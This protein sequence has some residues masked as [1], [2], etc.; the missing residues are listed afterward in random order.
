MSRRVDRRHGTGNS[1]TLQVSSKRSSLPPDAPLHSAAR[2]CPPCAA[3]IPTARRPAGAAPRSAPARGGPGGP[4]ARDLPQMRERAAAPTAG[5][6]LIPAAPTR[7]RDHCP[8]A[9]RLTGVCVCHGMRAHAPH[10]ERHGRNAGEAS[11]G[12]TACIRCPSCP[13]SCLAHA[14]G[15]ACSC[16]TLHACRI[17]TPV[18]LALSFSDRELRHAAKRHAQRERCCGQRYR[19]PRQCLHSDTQ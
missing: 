11:R 5:L 6:H 18:L 1:N 14:P 2:A 10:P 17:L 15:G 9:Q 13:A 19:Y 7:V 8:A 12:R 16:N 3:D 4:D